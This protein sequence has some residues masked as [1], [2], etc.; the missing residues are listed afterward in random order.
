[1]ALKDL[2]NP[3]KRAPT[4]TL[5]SS[6]SVDTPKGA[7]AEVGSALASPIREVVPDLN[8][9][10]QEFKTYYQ[11]ANFHSTS[12]S[13]LRAVKSAVNG[14][15]F[16]V[17]P[18]S[19]EQEDLDIAEFVEYNLTAAQSSPWRVTLNRILKFCDYGFSTFEHV[20]EQ[21]DWAPKRKNAN[22][23]SYTMLRKLAPRPAV[24]ISEIKYDDAGG[25][26]EVIQQALR[27]DGKV[28]EVHI[29]IQKLLIFTHDE[30]GGDLFGKSMLR[31]AYPHWFY[32]QHL[33]KVDAIQKERH[34]IGVPYGKL[35][36]GYTDKDRDAAFEM[37]TNL[38]TNEKA[39]V[40]FPEG[41]EFG[42]LKVEGNMVNTLDSVDHHNAMI[43]LNVLAEFLMA[44]LTQGGA[45]ATSASQQ[46]I[47]T[48]ANRSMADMI[49]DVFNL[50]LV[51]LVVGFNFDTDR[52]PLVKARNI[53]DTRDQQQLAAGL[54]NLFAQEV[55]TP[56]LETENW[57]RR[58]FDMPRKIGDR[59]EISPT[60]IRKIIN[61]SIMT[62]GTGGSATTDT[63]GIPTGSSQLKPGGNGGKGNIKPGANKP[64]NMGKGNNVS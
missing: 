25:P 43:M 22:H 11:M 4:T 26:V 51:P 52:F 50:Y 38:R 42:F 53:G 49:C 28:N 45:R 10:R 16:Y 39:G 2:V 54:A 29:P 59:P 9:K 23:K 41:Y 60:Q 1:L 46:D 18:S 30:D 27:A 12:R 33:Y 64:G 61:Q 34:G 20:W 57:A 35:P 13:S 21:R 56:D 32:I 44:G 15:E 14:A 8:T 63:G 19:E 6:G 31:S 48:K 47:F 62:P 37:V 17:E 7:D 40:V 3:L 55:I 58:A 24:S 36:P 5:K